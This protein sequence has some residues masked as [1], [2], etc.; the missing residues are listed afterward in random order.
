M[1]NRKWQDAGGVSRKRQPQWVLVAGDHREARDARP[2]R[3]D[4]MR[5]ERV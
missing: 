5:A 2:L 4:G 1:T 3:E